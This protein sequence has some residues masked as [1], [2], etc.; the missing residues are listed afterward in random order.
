MAHAVVT[1]PEVPYYSGTGPISF[2]TLRS[3]WLGVNSGP[4]KASTF[5]RNLNRDVANPVVG[6]STENADIASDPFNAQSF[7]SS[8]T[9]GFAFSGTGRDWKISQM[10]GSIKSYTIN[11]T[12]SAT[13]DKNV[14]GDNLE[15]NSNLDKTI[16]KYYNIQGNIHAVTD[17]QP[18]TTE[19][20]NA[21]KFVSNMI[22]NLNIEVSGSVLG[23]G[24][25]G[26]YYLDKFDL[27]NTRGEP[28]GHAIKLNSDDGK[29]IA[30]S[31][32]NTGK[33]YGG[34][35]GG[36]R[37][38]QG[39][40]GPT[41]VYYASRVTGGSLSGGIGEWYSYKVGGSCQCE[42]YS[43]CNGHEETTWHWSVKEGTTG[44]LPSGSTADGG[45]GYNI[46]DIVTINNPNS[47]Y[48]ATAEVTK[49]QGP[50]GV[51]FDA[52]GNL[53]TSDGTTNRFIRI[54]IGWDD[55]KGGN[56][57]GVAWESYT[58][59]DLGVDFQVR[60]AGNNITE[61]GAR[62]RLIEV[63]PNKVY[64]ANLTRGSGTSTATWRHNNN[65][66]FCIPDQA[67][68][69]ANAQIWIS[70]PNNVFP[71]SSGQRAETI[72][73]DRVAYNSLN[74]T[75]YYWPSNEGNT[76]NNGMQG[77]YPDEVDAAG[78]P[79]G[80]KVQIRG[81]VDSDIMSSNT[82]TDIT[83]WNNTGLSTIVENG[84]VGELDVKTGGSRYI[85][86]YDQS[87]QTTSGGSGTGLKVLITTAKGW[88]RD[89][90]NIKHET[91]PGNSGQ[92]LML[93]SGTYSSNAVGGGCAC[94][95]FFCRRTCIG[96]AY[97][98]I[99]DPVIGIGAEGG[100]G[101]FGGQGRGSNGAGN[102]L[103]PR[104]DGVAGGTNP[105]N[106]PTTTTDGGIGGTGGAGGDW[107]IA[108]GDGQ[109][110]QCNSVCVNPE[111]GKDGGAAGRAIFGTNYTVNDGNFNSTRVKGAYQP[112]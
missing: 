57:F 62:T 64:T 53:V 98:I 7:E 69:D 5:F 90:N 17:L 37:G 77:L 104:T 89:G 106:P 36:G 19:P 107:A 83:P 18:P 71:S 85:K 80:S 84:K 66:R 93:G 58:I 109:D 61:W 78:N 2:S 43:N 25:K 27:G 6:D 63:E 23:S 24:G 35:G 31:V 30:V 96:A 72:N 48:S 102:A 99:E 105:A 13:Y 110:G 74:R 15:W 12:D 41:G 11:Q 67:G 32:T 45:S 38:G 112:S 16:P 65:Q 95:I 1:N 28:G 51:S 94:N 10:R 3:D 82:T 92:T 56:D 75:W 100:A 111:S 108:G 8:L 88:L 44:A 97:C 68:T 52:N 103:M 70:S 21:L 40:E 29:G 49:L 79:T 33:I 34:G 60:N 14:D 47:G 76:D 54:S 4:V 81:M 9:G 101:G 22:T 42:W 87:V 91:R 26:G 55:E 59:P 50:P 39:S 73:R 46:G 20:D 86:S